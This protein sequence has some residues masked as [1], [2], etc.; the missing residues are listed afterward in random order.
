M[1]TKE[2]LKRSNDAMV[3]FLKP[4]CAVTVT[5]MAAIAL[6]HAKSTIRKRSGL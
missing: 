5:T 1:A 4:C 3:R 6:K 2:Q